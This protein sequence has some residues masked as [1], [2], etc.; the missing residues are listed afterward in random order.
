MSDDRLKSVPGVWKHRKL[1]TAITASLAAGGSGL[2]LAQNENEGEA[3]SAAGA[4]EEVT[5]TAR[6][7]EENIQDIPQ[8]IQAFSQQEIDRVG[9]KGL[10]DVAKF[11][12][13][14]TV[15][16]SS[17]GLNKIV[18]RGL[19]DS[20]RPYIADAPAAIYLDEQ[21]LTTGAQ[22]PNIRPTR[23]SSPPT[24]AAACTP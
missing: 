14:M 1:F 23:P 22:S 7:R 9:I 2:A 24:L 21:P 3:E 4:L 16:S 18:F 6:K 10:Q 5:V 8:S 13:S 20:V 15:V 19:A 17:A 12:P 11:V